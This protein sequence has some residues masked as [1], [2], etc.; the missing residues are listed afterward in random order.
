[1][2]R[3]DFVKTTGVA[4]SGT[5]LANVAGAACGPNVPQELPN[6]LWITSE[7]NSAYF[8][9]CYGNS[10][11]TTPNID[12]L[13]SEGFLYTHAYGTNAVCSPSRNTIITGAYSTSNGNENMRSNYPKSDM[14]HTYPEYLR[15]AGYYCT[16]NVKTDYNTPSID[17]AAIWDESSNT[18]HYKNRPEGQPFFAVFNLMTSHESS[19]HRQIPTEELRHDPNQVTLPP[20]HPDTPEMRHDWAQYYD[21]IEDMDGQVGELLQE[22]EESGLADSTIVFYYGDHGGV[23]AR[24]KR[25]VYETGTQVPFVIRIPERYRYLYPARNPGDQVVRLVNFVDLA[26]TLLSIARIPIPDYMQGHAFLGQ[27]QTS[28]PEYT[29]MSRLRMDER[30]DMV[31]AARGQRFRYIR[32]YMPFRITM[33]HVD[34]L[35][36]APSAQSWEDAYK[37]GTTNEVQSRFFQPKPVEEL[38]DT[39][40]DYWEINNLAD[41][42]EYA[43]VLE[44]MRTALT[45]WQRE[46]RD[47]GLIPETDY[48]DFAGDG[49]M[50]DYMRSPACPFDELLTAANLAVLGGPEALNTFIEY[51]K[52]DNSGLRYWG[53]T[54]ILILKD[55]ARPAIPALKQ[56]AGDRSGAVATLVAEA[57]YGLG[58]REAAVQAYVN[59]L[60]NTAD[61]AM[62]DRNFALN[63]IDAIDDE[64]PQIVS[65]VQQLYDEKSESVT[66][67]ARYSVYDFLMSEYLLKKWGRLAEG[68]Q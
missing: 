49:S 68:D 20:Y 44:R 63:S 47:V 5:A 67:F 4:L 34:Y 61:Y 33:Q 8:A 23:L 57:L 29:F 36:N 51:L 10:F 40:D 50:Y 42:P 14:V 1:M 41:D 38:Y 19:I 32:N 16:N 43:D 64:S 21:M 60:Q 2:K 6:I 66:G 35:F 12:G 62:T 17:P 27:Q 3:R 37:A 39:E 55:A 11:A 52:S 24:S 53:A 48:M 13:A 18:A 9:G 26:P 15:E 54:G 22:L 46:I 7:D 56:A 31:R 59:L 65:A 45:D 58:E 30:Y 25:F 28:D